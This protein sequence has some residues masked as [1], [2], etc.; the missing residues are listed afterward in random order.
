[1]APRILIFGTGSIGATYA[2]LLSRA[3][4]ATNIVTVCRSNFQSAS[5]NGFTIHSTLWGENQTVKPV[6]VRSVDDAAALNADNPFDYVI[7]CSKA[8]PTIPSTAEL[9]KPAVSSRTTIVLIQNGIAIEEPYAKLFPDNPLL[10]TVVYLPV[11]QISPG[12]VQHKEVELL[13]IGAYPASSGTESAQ[14]L[15]DL[16]KAAGATAEVHEDVQFERWSK[17][18]VNASW[19]PMCALSRSRDAEILQSSVDAKD[20]IRE[21][22]LEIASVANA[23]GYSKIDA[24]L[25]DFQ[26]AR[27]TVRDLPGVEP[28]MMADAL[29][30]RNMEVE[31]IVGSVVR[32]AKEHEIKTPMLRTVYVLATALNSS[33]ARR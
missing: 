19:N 15:A 28:S 14:K 5:Q 18:L 11:T 10:S 21:V 22:M 1:M 30:G 4:P 27:A 6:V 7:V 9:I 23:C 13:H 31:A 17:L 16:L 8:L 25:V 32:L 12:I 2:F 26:L 24:A 33:F 3:V 20:V 29:A